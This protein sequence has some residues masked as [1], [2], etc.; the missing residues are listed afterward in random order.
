M[1]IFVYI[2]EWD[3]MGC[4]ASLRGYHVIGIISNDLMYAGVFENWRYPEM[5][6]G[7]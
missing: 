6:H 3:R 5:R 4:S 1:D 2:M 7:M